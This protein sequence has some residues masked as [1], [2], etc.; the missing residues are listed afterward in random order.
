MTVIEESTVVLLLRDEVAEIDTQIAALQRERARRNEALLAL[1]GEALPDAPGGPV[2]P[3]ATADEIDA[4]VRAAGRGNV[5][6]VRKLLRAT[7]VMSQRDLSTQLDTAPG[8][9]SKAVKALV[10]MGEIHPAGKEG[11]S[12]LWTTKKELVA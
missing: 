8:S 7:T 12:P 4:L 5:E 10:A 9:I 2:T 11:R 6:A 1:T 3:R